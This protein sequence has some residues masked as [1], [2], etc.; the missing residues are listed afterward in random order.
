VSFNWIKCPAD[1]D[2]QYEFGTRD[3]GSL[4]PFQA[5]F[6]ASVHKEG[7]QEK[8]ATERWVD[9]RQIIF[10]KNYSSYQSYQNMTKGAARE[11]ALL[12]AV[13][14][15]NGFEDCVPNVPGAA[16]WWFIMMAVVGKP[17]L[18]SLLP[19]QCPKVNN[20]IP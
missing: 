16:W 14:Y 15:A 13:A 11:Q 10:A 20:V 9:Q 8:A 18:R 19:Q 2:S 12:D 6:E 4:N 3:P 17:P 5:A 7:F 1:Y